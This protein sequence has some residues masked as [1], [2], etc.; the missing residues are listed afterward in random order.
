MLCCDIFGQKFNYLLSEINFNC[1]HRVMLF[2]INFL[3]NNTMVVVAGLNYDLGGAILYGVL[4]MPHVS[5]G[6]VR[7]FK[8]ARTGF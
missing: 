1:Q 4:L 6:R 8:N 5:M 2:L 3:F 7:Q